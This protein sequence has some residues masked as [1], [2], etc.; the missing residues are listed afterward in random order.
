MLESCGKFIGCRGESEM[1]KVPEIGTV[2]NGSKVGTWK[3]V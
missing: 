2:G 3:S 1:T